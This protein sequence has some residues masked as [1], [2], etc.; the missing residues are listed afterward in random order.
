MVPTS[1]QFKHTWRG[2]A[3]KVSPIK[4]CALGLGR[5]EQNDLILDQIPT[6]TP[7]C[8]WA[9]FY[10]TE[11]DTLISFFSYLLI[12]GPSLYH[13]LIKARICNFCFEDDTVQARVW[14]AFFLLGTQTGMTKWKMRRDFIS[15]HCWGNTSEISNILCTYLYELYSIL[16][17]QSFHAEL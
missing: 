5:L 16:F 2:S 14:E 13:Y 10:I 6:D 4:H 15:E 7:G 9:H 3:F 1:S 8:L 11:S 17:S 12:L